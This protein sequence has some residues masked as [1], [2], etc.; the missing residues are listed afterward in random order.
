MSFLTVRCRQCRHRVSAVLLSSMSL[1][2]SSFR[3]RQQRVVLSL[4][5]NVTSRYG[6]RPPVKQPCSNNTEPE[7]STSTATD[8]NDGDQRL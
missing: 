1:K 6:A 5:F 8:P 4:S 2:K 7:P 3:K